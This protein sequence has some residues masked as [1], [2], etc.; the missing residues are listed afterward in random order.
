VQN[1]QRPL[2]WAQKNSGAPGIQNTSWGELPKFQSPFSASKVAM[3]IDGNWS[4]GGIARTFA[5]TKL[6]FGVTS[7]PRK[8]A[9]MPQLTWSG[10]WSY[11]ISHGVKDAA[12][13]FQLATTFLNKEYQLAANAASQAYQLKMSAVVRLLPREHGAAGD[14]RGAAHANTRPTFRRSTAPGTSASS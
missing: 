12:A 5:E 1:G 3:F 7:I 10:G 9:A 13:A 14:R 4:L 8:D 11:V 6:N 2:A